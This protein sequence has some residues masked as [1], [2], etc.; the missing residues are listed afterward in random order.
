MIGGFPQFQWRKYSLHA[1]RCNVVVA[2]LEAGVD[3][4]AVRAITGHSTV[5]MVNQY[6]AKFLAEQAGLQA[7]LA[8]TKAPTIGRTLTE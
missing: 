6:G 3:A 1:L 5:E 7:A 4:N 2:L 8:A